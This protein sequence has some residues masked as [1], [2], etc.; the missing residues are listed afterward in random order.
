[1]SNDLISRSALIANCLEERENWLTRGRGDG[2]LNL[3]ITRVQNAPAV[4]AAP[5]VHGRWI[6]RQYPLPL[7]DG[8]VTAYECSNCKTHWDSKTPC[9]PQCGAKM[10]KEDNQ[11]DD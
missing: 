5:V 1:M 9:C 3:V 2:G 4:D 8:T 11:C 6:E 10:D 7:S